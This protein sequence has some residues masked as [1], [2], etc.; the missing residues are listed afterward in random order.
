MIKNNCLSLLMLFFLILST[1]VYSSE[2]KIC[3]Y[4]DENFQGESL[5]TTEGNAVDILSGKWNDS[6]SSIEIPHGMVVSVF[7]DD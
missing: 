1:N 7:K 3:F 2:P 6:I 4:I 5:C